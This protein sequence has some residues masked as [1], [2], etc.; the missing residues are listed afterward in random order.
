[1]RSQTSLTRRCLLSH[2]R[3][4]S[5]MVDLWV[6]AAIYVGFKFGLSTV[7]TSGLKGVSV[8]DTA[9]GS[10]VVADS[11]DPASVYTSTLLHCV[12]ELL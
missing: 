5:N 2:E 8:D 6:A 9:L 7:L 3:L 11:L 4:V 10:N 1:M 12:T